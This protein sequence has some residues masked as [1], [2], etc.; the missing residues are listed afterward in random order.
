MSDYFADHNIGDDPIEGER[1]AY[2]R[3]IWE[4]ALDQML[5]ETDPEYRQSLRIVKQLGGEM[6]ED[7]MEF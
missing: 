3:D 2:L 4:A 6:I 7:G 1:I 5:Q